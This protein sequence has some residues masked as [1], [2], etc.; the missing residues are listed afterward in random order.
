MYLKVAMLVFAT[1]SVSSAAVGVFAEDGAKW[2]N[3][4][5]L[6][7]GM[8]NLCFCSSMTLDKYKELRS[9]H[10]EIDNSI[11]LTDASVT[12]HNHIEE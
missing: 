12:I 3:L 7:G 9:K 11:H 8:G 6:S 1:I 5:L 2:S 4:A 10:V